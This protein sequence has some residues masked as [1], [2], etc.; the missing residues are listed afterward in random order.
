MSPFINDSCTALKSFPN[1]QKRP[2]KNDKGVD[3]WLVAANVSKPVE[4]KL[5]D[6]MDGFFFA[7]NNCDY[8]QPDKKFGGHLAVGDIQYFVY[9]EKAVSSTSSSKAAMPSPSPTAPPKGPP[10]APPK[11]PPKPNPWVG[12]VCNDQFLSK[13]A[14]YRKFDRHEM[15]NF[16]NKT[17]ASPAPDDNR[18][19]NAFSITNNGEL[20]M[21]LKSTGRSMKRPWDAEC[22]QGF[23]A[24]V[25]NCDRNMEKKY[26]GYIIIQQVRFDVA[27][28]DTNTDPKKCNCAPKV[29][30]PFKRADMANWIREFCEGTNALDTDLTRFKDGPGN[31]PLVEFHVH[32]V[33][34]RQVTGLDKKFCIKGFETAIDHCNKGDDKKKGDLWG[35]KCTLNDIV[36]QA[37]SSL[38]DPPKDKTEDK[39]AKDGEF[40]EGGDLGLGDEK[41]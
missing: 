13:S 12:E 4:F 32:P 8:E 18:H 17:C 34:K 31:K 11:S 1:R 20:T 15:Y 14:P 22:I 3:L 28:R 23:T 5:K 38:P 21:D 24:V 9:A 10:P 35:G 41:I 19:L 26:G 7:M 30:D 36:F 39:P 40:G 6:C 33:K 25:D 16:I 2:A 29:G 37:R 27:A